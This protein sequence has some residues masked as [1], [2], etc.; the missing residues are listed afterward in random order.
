MGGIKTRCYWELPW[1]TYWEP[2]GNLK[3]TC[4]EQRQNEK[5]LL[6]PPPKPLKKRKQCTLSSCWA[7][8]LAAWNFYLQNYLSPFLAWANNSPIINWGYL[9]FTIKKSILRQKKNFGNSNIYHA[10][11]YSSKKP[12]KRNQNPSKYHNSITNLKF[13]HKPKYHLSKILM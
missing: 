5:I 8:S 12:S 11:K 9:P 6:P 10:K 7:F 4:W 1:G 13:Q 2:H 3:G